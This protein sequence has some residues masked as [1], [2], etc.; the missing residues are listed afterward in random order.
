M[1]VGRKVYKNMKGVQSVIFR[2]LSFLLVGVLMVVFPDKVTTWLVR[3]LG[4]LF[5]VPGLVSIGSFFRSYTKND[6]TR[7]LLPI[8][9]VGSVALGIILII[10]PEKFI[11]GLVYFLAAAIILAGVTAIV[12]IVHFR[13]Y[14]SVSF[15]FY[16]IPVLLCATGIYIIFMKQPTDA[17]AQI[18]FSVPLLIFGVASIV[19]G[20]TELVYAIHFRKIYRLIRDEKK[21]LV[22]SQSLEGSDDE[23]AES[24]GETTAENG[25]SQVS[26]EEEQSIDFSVEKDGET[27]DDKDL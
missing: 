21:K 9:G 19:Y 23:V 27:N 13:K 20:L 8:I 2:A 24:V 5:V 15:K 11:T 26:K 18:V 1:A 25:S 6:A 12:N 14:I 16:I 17:D 7:F 10:W 4:V 22:E 3:I